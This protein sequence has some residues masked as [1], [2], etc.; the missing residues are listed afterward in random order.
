MVTLLS[1]EGHDICKKVTCQVLLSVKVVGKWVVKHDN[2]YPMIVSIDVSEINF[3]KYF[4]Q[5]A[6]MFP[7]ADNDGWRWFVFAVFVP[8]CCSRFW[9]WPEHYKF[10]FKKINLIIFVF[11]VLEKIHRWVCCKYVQLLSSSSKTCIFYPDE[12]SPLYYKHDCYHQVWIL[13]ADMG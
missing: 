7:I 10:M 1:K 2:Q 6:I 11:A 8:I 9:W 13:V 5:Y 3:N 4:S 12:R